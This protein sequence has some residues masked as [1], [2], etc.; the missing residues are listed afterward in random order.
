[1]CIPDAEEYN[2]VYKI[3]YMWGSVQSE[4]N[5]YASEGEGDECDTSG[6]QVIKIQCMLSENTAC[7]KCV[8]W[9]GTG[10]EC[11]VY[12]T[13]R[14]RIVNG[15]AGGAVMGGVRCTCHDSSPYSAAAR[16]ASPR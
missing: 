14:V 4:S 5:V 3:N 8:M 12:C 13:G 9:L 15:S 11:E 6:M 1:M 2:N 7:A 10:Y 16:Q